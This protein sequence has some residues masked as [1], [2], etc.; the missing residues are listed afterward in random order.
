MNVPPDNPAAHPPQQSG[1]YSS[2]SEFL[3]FETH[4]ASLENILCVMSFVMSSCRNAITSCLT[5]KLRQVPQPIS[6][7]DPAP[8][9]FPN[10]WGTSSQLVLGQ[11]VSRRPREQPLVEFRPQGRPAGRVEVHGQR[12]IPHSLSG[13]F[14]SLYRT[15]LQQSTRAGR[16]LRTR[17]AGGRGF[18]PLRLVRQ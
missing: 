11:D 9:P 14:V 4:T 7:V 12:S 18:S 8:A 10:R 3:I 15:S 6:T 2:T 16:Q 5:K 17:G 13:V 1:A